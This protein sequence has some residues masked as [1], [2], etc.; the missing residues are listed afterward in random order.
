MKKSLEN[1]API[2][3]ITLDSRESGEYSKRP[4][5]AL[6]KNYAQMV[7]EA[8]GVP[9]FLTYHTEHVETY[10]DMIDGLLIPG[11][12]FDID[13]YIYGAKTIH[14]KVVINKPRT[15]FELTITKKIY[16]MRKPVFGI[17]GGIQLINVMLGG[18]LIQDIP[19]MVTNAISHQQP[20][21]MLREEPYHEIEVERGTLLHDIVGEGKFRVNSTHHQSIEKL[22]KNLT[23]NA[24]A[25]D[26]IIE[27]ISIPQ[28]IYPFCLGVQWHP[29][30]QSSSH[31]RKLF[32][33]FV[34]ACKKS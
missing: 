29:E 19:D 14:P 28:G 12:D 33:A 22:G 26:G 20:G 2:I 10:A 5:Y 24:K 16:E 32:E 1:P 30:Y 31:D 27:A 13:P 11:G 15:E 4:F 3:G 23:L 8:G 25:P 17:C 9:I 34:R 6:R 7:H 18:S 21:D